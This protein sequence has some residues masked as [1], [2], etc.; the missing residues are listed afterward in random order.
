MAPFGLF[1]P[2]PGDPW[3]GFGRLRRE[4]DEVFERFGARSLA[5]SRSHPFPPVNVYETEDGYVLSAE[6]PGLA[7]EDLDV[8]VEGPRVTLRGERRIEHPRGA[9]LHRRE[10][11]AGTFRRT[12][13]LPAAL[14]PEKAQ[15]VYRHGVLLLR[16][17]KAPSAQAR[18]IAVEAD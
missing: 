8:A 18:R 2:W 11:Q 17:P 3:L 4:L 9:S 6:L 5:T 12:L 1:D 15:A 10:R 16:L 7:R 13:E 14:D